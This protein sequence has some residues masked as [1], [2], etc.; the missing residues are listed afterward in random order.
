MR[1]E[2]LLPHAFLTRFFRNALAR[3]DAPAGLQ[4]WRAGWSLAMQ[5]N[6]CVGKAAD[7]IGLE[8]ERLE[9]T[10]EESSVLESYGVLTW[11]VSQRSPGGYED[12]LVRDLD[13]AESADEDGG[14]SEAAKVT[15]G[16]RYRYG[17]LRLTER[18]KSREAT[19]SDEIWLWAFELGHNANDQYCIA[20]RRRETVER[21]VVE[22]E[23]LHIEHERSRP[24]LI[25]LGDQTEYRSV[26]ERVSWEH[27]FLPS[28]LRADIARTVN[29]FFEARELYLRH[30]LTHRRGILLAGPPG[31]GKTTILKAI[32]TTTGVPVI[33][34]AGLRSDFRGSVIQRAFDRASALAPA[35]LCFEDLDALVD[36][37]PELSRFLN[38]LDGLEVLEGILVIATTNRPDRI[39]PA[40][41]KRPSRFDR[42]FAIPTP[43]EETRRGYLEHLLESAGPTDAPKTI[44]RQ[45]EGFS[46][47]FLKELIVQ[48]R[49]SAIRR[50]DENV[51]DADLEE[52][53]ECTSEHMRL[54]SRDLED[55]G[56]FGFE[57]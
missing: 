2:D 55:R 19:E 52:A 27:V 9:P 35:I 31:N 15:F 18:E 23:T 6:R 8:V 30:G 49:L 20:T 56:K 34:A 46:M 14:S 1:T 12:E 36:D 38:L 10:E 4:V 16:P 26:T 47:A 29:E 3:R 41:A 7:R 37:G 50:G 54:A 11:S 21:L 42:V 5:C 25:V 53:L 51:T 22:A 45:T 32:G 57:T 28:D 33:V 48:A 13:G 44:A 17:L 40:I 24:G 39:D 43:T